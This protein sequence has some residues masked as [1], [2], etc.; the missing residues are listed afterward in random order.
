MKKSICLVLIIMFLIALL[1]SG[2]TNIT[3]VVIPDSVK[4]IR[5][6]G[7]LKTAAT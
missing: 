2:E 4:I 5:W 1:S 3:G 6:G 7:Y